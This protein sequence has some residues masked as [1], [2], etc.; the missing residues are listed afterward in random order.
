M[1]TALTHS[2]SPSSSSY[3]SYSSYTHSY[4]IHSLASDSAYQLEIRARNSYGWSRISKLHTFFTTKGTAKLLIKAKM[5]L[6]NQ[7]AISLDIKFLIS[8]CIVLQ[9][10]VMQWLP[11]SLI[12]DD[13]K[14]II[15]I[16]PA[17]PI[18]MYIIFSHTMLFSIFPEK[19]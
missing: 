17:R 4:L 1:V 13:T 14:S 18:H 2:S 19:S 3:S 6:S 10:I 9:C 5:I 11:C 12:N 8:P 7:T 16:I 15:T